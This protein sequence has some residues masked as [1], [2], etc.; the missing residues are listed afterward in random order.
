MRGRTAAHKSL[1]RNDKYNRSFLIKIVWFFS[2]QSFFD[3]LADVDRLSEE[4]A[5]PEL[6]SQRDY[7]KELAFQDLTQGKA[8]EV[9]LEQVTTPD[10][11][12]AFW[13]RLL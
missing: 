13:R 9:A 6:Q 1:V 7:E 2:P 4:Q 8:I 5:L 12:D 10:G 11:V 3:W